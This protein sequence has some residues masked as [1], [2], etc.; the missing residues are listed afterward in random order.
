MVRALLD[1]HAFLWAISGNVKLSRRAGEIFVGPSDLW[2]SVAS[3]WEIL[4]K[5]QSG[6][7]LLPQPTGPYLVKKLAQNKIGTLHVNLDHVLKLETLPMH[8]RDP[9][10]RLL[11]AQS[12]HE[13]LP[14]VTSDAV[15]VRY[16]VE[17]IW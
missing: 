8:H 13:K 3:I 5:A 9:F 2:L 10:D 6:K 7:I 11:I 12:V 1:T 17:I 4:I 16:P 14:L 15:F